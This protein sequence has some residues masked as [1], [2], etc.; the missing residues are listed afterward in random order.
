MGRWRDYQKV[1]ARPKKYRLV[2]T[3]VRRAE[4][5]EAF[6]EAYGTLGFRLV[7][8]DLPCNPELKSWRFRNKVS[9]G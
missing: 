6:V 4:T 2:A 5:M 7:S 3:G 8:M 1:V 9:R